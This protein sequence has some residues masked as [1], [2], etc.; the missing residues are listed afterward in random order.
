M[1]R[2]RWTAA[3]MGDPPRKAVTRYFR[4]IT[5]GRAAVQYRALYD[6]NRATEAER[7]RFLDRVRREMAAF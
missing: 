5:G 7:A 3:M 6:M 1:S 4:V 2:P